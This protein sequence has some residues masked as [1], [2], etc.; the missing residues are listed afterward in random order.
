M[1]RQ[2]FFVDEAGN[3][4]FS[5]QRDAS[6]YFILASVLMGDDGCAAA[7]SLLRLRRELVWEGHPLTD[8]FHGSNDKQVVR[9]HVF[10]AIS[11]MNIR[12]DATILE[13]RKAIVDQQ[14]M[15]AFYKL[16]WY[17]HAKHVIPEAFAQ[18]DELLVIAASIGTRR[19]QKLIGSAIKDVIN[20]CGRSS[21]STRVSYWP[22]LSDPCLQVT[23]YCCW[24]I[25]RKW[26]RG[27][28]R[29]YVL[30]KNLIGSE[31]DIFASSMETYY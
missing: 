14:E 19:E 9:D 2:H 27:D 29:S 5:S 7:E 13:K 25:Q 24:A 4:D 30:I 16:A 28:E 11:G 12:V 21:D 8:A 17:L 26:E 31:R 18:S 6:H 10:D 1:S 23:D 20:Q 22:A 15:T 3:F